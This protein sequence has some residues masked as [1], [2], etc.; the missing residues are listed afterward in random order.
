MSCWFSIQQSQ[1]QRIKHR[2]SENRSNS[3][4]VITVSDRSK[5]CK[6]VNHRCKYFGSICCYSIDPD[7][8]I[9]HWWHFVPPCTIPRP[10]TLDE[11]VWW[12]FIIVS[13]IATVY[14]MMHK[15]SI[16]SEHPW[17]P[18][19]EIPYFLTIFKDSKFG[20]NL[21]FLFWS[22]V[23]LT[24]VGHLIVSCK[25]STIFIFNLGEGG[26]VSKSIS[27]PTYVASSK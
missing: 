7:T 23:G 27:I 3:K 20:T 12:I 19:G 25:Y 14:T 2:N 13:S 8:I 5:V 22:F 15:H 1:K 17:D 4:M 16:V 6:S 9:K 11:E 26:T 21:I 24:R 10:L 18:E